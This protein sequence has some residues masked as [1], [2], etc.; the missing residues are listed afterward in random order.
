MRI[1]KKTNLLPRM[2]RCA[3]VQIK[4]PAALRGKWLETVRGYRRLWLEIGCGK[5]RFTAETA[6]RNPDAL[7]VA[8]E[9]APDAM[10]TGMERVCE[11]AIEN[12]RFI[13]SDAL[14]LPVIFGEGEV[15]RIYLNFCDPWPKNRD[16][17]HRL[18][19]PGFLAL[20]ESILSPAGVLYFKTDNPPLFDY[21]V[22]TL[23][24]AGWTL[25][26][27]TR[28]LHENG[29]AGVMTDYEAKFYEQGIKISR[30]AA[31]KALRG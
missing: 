7:L 19:A 25:S 21:A 8:I 30:L 6:A 22:E 26:E 23:K 18:I 4:D 13:D 9:K 10:V 12:V 29:P 20:Y 27:L 1:R 15:D 16:A 11:Q 24:Q 3:H 5:G 17:K 2:A 28:D 31:R 14:A